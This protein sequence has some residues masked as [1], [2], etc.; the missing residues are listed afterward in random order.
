MSGPLVCFQHPMLDA[1]TE[2]LVTDFNNTKTMAGPNTFLLLKR[3]YWRK[4]NGNKNN[5][6]CVWSLLY[7]TYN[8]DTQCSVGLNVGSKRG[9]WP[10]SSLD[11]ELYDWRRST[12][13]LSFI[14]R[15]KFKPGHCS[16]PTS[17][18]WYLTH[19]YHFGIHG[20]RRTSWSV[21]CRLQL[22]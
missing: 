2:A 14:S 18:T 15:P 21:V 7:S 5:S 10:L 11:S 17:R 16:S 13:F 4:I 3:L 12:S 9:T 8:T 20:K 1:E 22:L 6:K 19:S